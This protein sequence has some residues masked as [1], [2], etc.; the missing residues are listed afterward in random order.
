MGHKIKYGPMTAKML[1][2]A[3]APMH[4]RPV[5]AA[6]R[7]SIVAEFLAGDFG[8]RVC[9]NHGVSTRKC[10]RVLRD[11]LGYDPAAYERDLRTLLG[12]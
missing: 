8:G 11:A 12:D 9:E 2:F 6:E 7:A 4:K 10:R 3:G 5:G 1:D